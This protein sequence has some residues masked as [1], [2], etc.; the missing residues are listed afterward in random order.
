MPTPSIDDGRQKEAVVDT[1]VDKAAPPLPAV[2][3]AAD[4]SALAARTHPRKGSRPFRPHPPGDRARPRTVFLAESQD[5]ILEQYDFFT[6]LW[7]EHKEMVVT[8]TGNLQ[9]G[10]RGFKYPGL[11][12]QQARNACVQFIQEQVEQSQSAQVIAGISGGL[13][14]AVTAYL[15]VEAL[16]RERVRF[17]HFIE[18]EKGLGVRS[19]ADVITRSLRCHLEMKDLRPLLRAADTLPAQGNPAQRRRRLAR[20]RMAVL[21]DLAESSKALVV[22]SI[23]KT[24]RLLGFGTEYGDL[25]CALNPAG[26]IYQSQ[27]LEMARHFNVPRAVLERA[28]GTFDHEISSA[29]LNRERLWKEMDFYLHQIADMRISL[30]YLQKQGL[31]EEKLLWLYRRLRLSASQGQLPLQA[32]MAGAYIPRLGEL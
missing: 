30:S 13:D 17:I 1:A 21:F 16:G 19:R 29:G 4:T 6:A 26:D 11:D 31:E 2:R 15:L 25:A 14:S 12:C 27:M 24:K 28:P 32:E 9:P 23:N 10:L 3:P 18:T 5:E 8:F 22:G 7:H 20:E